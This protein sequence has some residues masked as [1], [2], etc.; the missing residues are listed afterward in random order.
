M[1][2]G[3]NVFEAPTMPCLT[4]N[5]GSDDRDDFAAP[6]LSGLEYAPSALPI[7]LKLSDA[8]AAKVKNS[9][10]L[11]DELICTTPISSCGVPDDLYQRDS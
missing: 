3:A 4:H 9:R 8:E 7:E 5:R 11:K 10:R 1:K 2:D 6:A